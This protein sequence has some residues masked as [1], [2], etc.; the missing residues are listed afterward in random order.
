MEKQKKDKPVFQTIGSS[1]FGVCG[2][3][4]CNIAEH[5]KLEQAKKQNKEK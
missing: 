3:D 5:R 4:G 1:D 2:P